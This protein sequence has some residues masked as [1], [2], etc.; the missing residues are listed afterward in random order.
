MDSRKLLVCVERLAQAVEVGVT[1]A[2]GV[3]VAAV[4]VTIASE[5]VVGVC[6]TTASRL[7]DVVLVVLARV[8]RKGKCICVGFP[9]GVMLATALHHVGSTAPVLCLPHVNLS[10]ASPQRPD[11]C[12]HVV[13]RRLPALDVGLAA[14]KL[15]IAGALGIAVLSKGSALGIAIPRS[16]LQPTPVPYLA[17]ALLAE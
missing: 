6:S 5:A 15:E 3:V 13:G 2:V 16:R 8:R 14:D 17:P 1:H 7:A 12:V 9:W 10:T 11:S 4:G